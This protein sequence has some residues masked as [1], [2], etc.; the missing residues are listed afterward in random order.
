[1]DPNETNQ[2]KPPNPS[3]PP[4]PVEAACLPLQEETSLPLLK[5]P[6]ITL[7]GGCHE[8]GSRSQSDL[9][10]HSGCHWTGIYY[11]QRKQ[12]THQKDCKTDGKLLETHGTCVRMDSKG[13]RPR[14]VKYNTTYGLTH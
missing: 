5:I 6:R 8:R 7:S 12:L 4:L 2:L 11:D 1:M 3:E 13:V 9:P 14:K 10:T